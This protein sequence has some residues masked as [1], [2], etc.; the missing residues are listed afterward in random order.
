M[1]ALQRKYGRGEPELSSRCQKLNERVQ[2]Y[3]TEIE[4]LANLAY[5]G[6]PD[7]VQERLKIDAFLKRL[8]DAELKKAVWTLYKTT[9]TETLGFALTQE[10]ASGL[11]T[12]SMKVTRT[13]VGSEGDI[14]DVVCALV[15]QVLRENK[16]R[17]ASKTRKCYACQKPGH[18]ARECRSKHKGS[19]STSPTRNIQRTGVK[20]KRVSTAGQG[21]TPKFSSPRDGITQS[22]RSN[23]SL[24]IDG[25]FR[26]VI[27]SSRWTLTAT[28]DE[29]AIKGKTTRN[30]SISDIS[31]KHEFLV[32]DIMDGVILGMDFM[33]KHGFVFDMKRQVF[34]YVNV[35]LPLTVGYE[36]Q[37]DV[38]QVVVQQQQKINP[39][40]EA[41][42]WATAT[43][44]I[45]LSKI[46]VVEPS[47]ECTKDNIIFGKA[48]VLPVNNLIPVRVLNPTSDTTKVQKG[49]IIAQCEKAEYVCLLGNAD[50]DVRLPTRHE[51]IVSQPPEYHLVDRVDQRFQ[52]SDLEYETS[53]HRVVNNHRAQIYYLD[54]GSPYTCA[55]C[56]FSC[57]PVRLGSS[58]GHTLCRMRQGP[59][60]DVGAMCCSSPTIVICGGDPLASDDNFSLSL[61]KHTVLSTTQREGVRGKKGDK[62][63]NGAADP[64]EAEMNAAG[65]SQIASK[66]TMLLNLQAT[67][68]KITPSSGS[69]DFYVFRG[70][71]TKSSVNNQVPIENQ[72]EI[73]SGSP[74]AYFP[75]SQEIPKFQPELPIFGYAKIAP[76]RRTDEQMLTK[77]INTLSVNCDL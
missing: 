9:F 64:F 5:I 69:S 27:T 19:H 48:V 71:K 61:Y 60:G 75:F 31:M 55:K 37:A 16:R 59:S 40:S 1:D 21:L 35:T 54:A 65:T 72:I 6:V 46:R 66:L 28:G 53:F 36:R 38:L 12:S 20:L 2:D 18:F 68:R 24:T 39:K 7:D 15:R 76:R 13:E 3:A 49:D 10:A 77:V 44:E 17:P 4:R 34:Q 50:L 45:R 58:G 51:L 52:N 47:K 57:G 63:K 14:A 30:I 33:A 70:I 74:H 43:Q 41:I 29:A 23:S 8:R 25:L 67:A 42:T 22:Q 62:A 26:A 56:H 11:W 73:T 32:A